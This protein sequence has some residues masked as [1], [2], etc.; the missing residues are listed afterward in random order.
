MLTQVSSP[1]YSFAKRS[2]QRSRLRKG[3]LAVF[4]LACSGLLPITLIQLQKIMLR[5]EAVRAEQQL[6]TDPTTGLVLAIQAVGQNRDRLPGA[7]LPEVQSSLLEAVQT[8]RERNRFQLQTP[9]YTATFSPNSQTIAAAGADGNLYLWDRKGEHRTLSGRAQSTDKAQPIRSLSFSSDGMQV[10]G[11]TDTASNAVQRWSLKQNALVPLKF[12]SPSP[13]TA[14]AFSADG[15]EIVTGSSDGRVRLWNSQQQWIGQLLAPT[16]TVTAVSLTGGTIASSSTDGRLS[17]WNTKGDLLGQLG[18]NSSIQSMRVDQAGQRIIVQDA[19]HQHAFFWN[20]QAQQWQQSVLGAVEQVQSVDL[21]PDNTIAAQGLK[22]GTLYLV[23]ATPKSQF[24]SIPLL[25]HQGQI[26]IVRFSPNVKTLMSGGADGS[27]RLWDAFDGTLLTRSHAQE[28]IAAVLKTIA[29]SPNGQHLV[30]WDSNGKLYIKDI[31]R[32]TIAQL[33]VIDQNKLLQTAFSSNGQI[34]AAQTET[35]AENGLAQ[36]IKLWRTDSK[37]LADFKVLQTEGIQAFAVNNQGNQIAQISE[38]GKLQL[39]NTQGQ[40]LGETALIPNFTQAKFLQFSPDGQ[41]LISGT[42]DQTD[43]AQS[44]EQ[45]KGQ[46]CL[47]S[48]RSGITQQSCQTISS[49]TAQI[50]SDGKA[51]AIGST[52][53]KVYLWNLQTQQV[54]A[55]SALSPDSITALAFSPDEQTI[56]SGSKDGSVHLLDSQLHPTGQPFRGHQSPIQSVAFNQQGQ[57]IVSVS[58]DGE[59]RLWQG[60][61]EGWLK[62]ACD[63]LQAH[64]IFTNPTTTAAKVAK[65][66]CQRWIWSAVQSSTPNVSA[67]S[68]SAVSTEEAVPQIVRLVVKLGDRR[69]YVYRGSNIEASYPIAIGRPG[70]ETPTGNFRVFEMQRNPGWTHPLTNEVVAPGSQNPLG[71]R[72]IAFWSDGFNAAG[73]HGTPDQA[74]VGQA[75]SHGCLRM[76]DEDVR[77]L[78]EWVKLGTSVSVEP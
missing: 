57:T 30:V 7:I 74:S 38:T 28:G 56:V 71:S 22:D 78:Y 37:I 65:S 39:W 13:I 40:L 14:A 58:Q 64:P 76:R 34:I 77:A 59:I 52:D 45:P 73:F 60:N 63:R 15:E 36:Q 21:S 51:L 4:A 24:P 19:K 42:V 8:A 17:F 18:V 66:T 20:V 61:W 25:G 35:R 69:V 46:I 48:I 29:S 31:D 72:W 41:F 12:D 6:A 11:I 5:N 33:D 53:G 10:I 16:G 32:K 62:T 23:P 43:Q 44:A 67:V 75:I 49:Q 3:I 68:T 1:D 54:T 47:W 27:I 70:W 50:R 9:I 2:P 26:N 55:S